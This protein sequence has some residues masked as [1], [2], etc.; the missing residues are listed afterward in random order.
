MV[1]KCGLS[2]VILAVFLQT[3]IPNAA[4]QT[5]TVPSGAAAA[6]ESPGGDKIICTD[7][8]IVEGKILSES[9]EQVVIM[10]RRG[11][12]TYQR[13]DIRRIEREP[14]KATPTPVPVVTPF[15]DIQKV[16]PS[17]PLNPISP[18]KVPQLH[19][20]ALS[21]I[22]QTLA[23]AAASTPAP[24]PDAGASTPAAEQPVSADSQK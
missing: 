20:F 21:V 8:T 22:R 16:L 12:F 24:T 15:Y 13:V 2:M 10:T 9:P 1:V 18:P 6:A 19:T 3:A 14:P 4:A 7:D 11:R 23:A 5:S 17:G